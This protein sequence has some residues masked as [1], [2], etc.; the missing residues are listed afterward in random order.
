MAKF[1]QTS[2][3]SLESQEAFED[4]GVSNSFPTKIIKF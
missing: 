2:E 4:I 3:L 1:E